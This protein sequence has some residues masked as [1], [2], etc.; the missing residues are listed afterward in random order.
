MKAI[1]CELCG[2][3]DIIKQE[4]YFVCQYCGT[5]YSVEEAKKMII[6][7][8]IEVTGEVKINESSKYE[9]YK[10]LA[11][12][13]FK[14]KLYEDAEEYY[15]KIL[16]INP[17]DWEA[18][19]K[20][21]LCSSWQSNLAEFKV[22]ETVKSS[23][24]ALNSIIN[25]PEQGNI[26]LDEVKSQMASD[27]NIL[28]VAFAQMAIKHYNEYWKLQESASE[29]W[30]RLEQ[31]IL[32]QEY[33]QTLIS[34]NMIN[35]NEIDKDVYIAI[36]KNIIFY[37]TEICKIRRYKTGQNE[38]G[39]L[40]NQIWYRNDLRPVII[41]KYNKN[42]QEVKL[43]DSSYIPEKIELNG[44]KKGCYI[45]TAVY[46]SYDCPEVWVLRRFRDNT[47]DRNW[48]GRLFIKCYYAVSPIMVKL[49]GQK[50]W[51]NQL[52]RNQLNKIVNDLKEKGYIDTPYKD[53]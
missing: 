25:L 35:K 45:A 41:Q 28:V 39:E 24:N 29:Y 44:K 5:K 32:A 22:Q 34:R 51:F 37:C 50:R 6:E 27:I 17:D 12:R 49:F 36:S 10:K 47:L 33:A 31:C 4:G 7:G 11:S 53:K 38:Y 9:N 16:E 48:Y 42:V 43:Y 40:Y 30:N 21:G 23:K 8:T 1:K 18:I 20:K 52:F 2:S 26:D 14:D 19:Y 46:G 3:N 15:N 13:A